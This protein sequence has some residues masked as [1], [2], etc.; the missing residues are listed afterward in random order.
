MIETDYMSLSIRCDSFGRYIFPK[1]G[2]IGYAQLHD[3]FLEHP[4]LTSLLEKIKVDGPDEE[5]DAE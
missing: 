1:I 3:I 4:Q 5:E 2:D